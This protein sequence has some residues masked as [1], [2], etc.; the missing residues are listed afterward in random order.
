MLSNGRVASARDVGNI[1][2]G[3]VAGRAGIP[4]VIFRAGADLLE[5]YQKGYA[6]WEKVN[7]QLPQYYGYQ[8]GRSLR[9][10]ET[11]KTPELNKHTFK[12]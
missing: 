8:Y 9:R 5:S 2:A 12:Y 1:G 11:I 6:T 3:I 4:W 10:N 7:S